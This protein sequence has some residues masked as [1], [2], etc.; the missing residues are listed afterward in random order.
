MAEDNLVA[1]FVAMCS[2]GGCAC[3]ISQN[4][5]FT[6]VRHPPDFGKKQTL[7]DGSKDLL[8][9]AVE[10]RF[11]N[12][13]K[14]YLQCESRGCELETKTDKAA[15]GYILSIERRVRV[16]ADDSPLSTITNLL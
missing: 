13:L 10:L 4:I 14:S 7:L 2:G 8:T 6:S 16:R 12:S 3:I 9:T 15:A 5:A 1:A 11:N